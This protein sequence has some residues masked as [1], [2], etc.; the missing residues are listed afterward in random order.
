[1][2][3]IARKSDLVLSSI[4]DT[5]SYKFSHFIEYPEGMDV[6]FSYFESRGGE[7]PT[8][9]LFGLQVIVHKYLSKQLTLADIDSA[10]EFAAAHGEPFYREGWLHVID[11]YDGY[12]PVRIR[13]IPEGTIVAPS[14][15]I[16]T[17][18]SPTDPKCF[19]ITNW[20]ETM[21]SRVWYPSTVATMS[22]EVK[23][24]WKEFLDKT[25]D[26]AAAE[27]AFK[28]HDFGARGVTCQ[29]QAMMGG[30]AHLLSF[31]GSDTVA[32]IKCA[33]HYYDS[34][35]AGFSI[36]ATEHST[37][38]VWG[39]ANEKAAL[40]RWIQKTLVERQVP[41]GVP[42]LSACV[43]DS[44]DIYKFA[45]MVCEPEILDL[46]RSSGGTLV[47]RPDSGE[48]RE[49]LSKVLF[50]LQENLPAGSVTVNKKG[51]LVL[52]NYLRVIWGDGI[53]RKSMVTILRRITELGWS[54]SNLAMGSGGGLLMDC[55]RDTQKFAFKCSFARV[56]G[57]SVD[58]IKD[59]ITDPGKKSKAGRLDLIRLPDG[60][61]KTVPLPEGM[62]S[63][64][65]S[66]MVTVFDTGK[67]TY[68]TTLDEIRE[69]MAL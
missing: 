51:Y 22:R 46:I 54:A 69:R 33:N 68:H 29:E 43:G 18:E 14:N 41:A 23:K 61:I 27:I 10:E 49:V 50:I 5:D 64:P 25:A 58:V 48:P 30:A 2:K 52:P 8:C 17:V 53:N 16:L 47:I 62:S 4:E 36:P 6:M 67:I 42:K 21:L 13:A 20:L 7:F 59:P 60:S 44:Y 32:G 19:W 12:L 55:N 9:T 34:S 63:H 45:Q 11:K 40:K 28:H 39:R 31:L 38:T 24:V 66:I 37:M 3:T 26:D 65:D 15:V 35:M 56:N 57:E 1:M